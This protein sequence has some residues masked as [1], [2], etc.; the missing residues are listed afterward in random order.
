MQNWLTNAT[1]KRIIQEIRKIM[2]DHPRYMDDSENVQNKFSFKER[3]NR[4]VIVN[5]ASADRVRLSADNYIGRLFSFVMQANVDNK[6]GKSLEWAV[7]NKTLLEEYS[8]QRDL[9]PSPPGVY[10]IEIQQLPDEAHQVPG[11]FTIDPSL[12]VIDELLITYGPESATEGQIAQENVLTDSVRLWM[13]GR[14]PLLVNVDYSVNNDGLITFLKSV[15]SGTRIYA[16]YRYNIERQGPFPFRYEEADL[17]SIP[18]TILA[19][20]R[21]AELCDKIAIVI[22]HS[23][24]EVAE[25][26]GG[27]FEVNFDITVFSRDSED[28]EQLSD[29]IIVKVLERQ[30]DLGYEGLE[31]IDI[32]PGGESEEIYDADTDDY[33]Y[34]SSLSLSIRVDWEIQKPL[35]INIFRVTSSSAEEEARAGLMDGTVQS[36][37]ITVAGN[38]VDLQGVPIM[39]NK[40]LTYER[41]K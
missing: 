5:N 10:V 39:K 37:L 8:P 28:R 16:D 21:R 20:G 31:L 3:P 38:L 34:D 18:G 2:Y 27:K 26:Y 33:Y 32:S 19:F 30:N 23:R 7:E 9:F 36:D 6:S 40:N 13:N 11:F 22:N 1:K 24:T 25:V 35:P 29:Y 14:Q 12:T 4:G 15:P 17:K 41:V